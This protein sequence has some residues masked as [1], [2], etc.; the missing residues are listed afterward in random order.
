[1]I[2]FP[3]CFLYKFFNPGLLNHILHVNFLKDSKSSFSRKI[4]FVSSTKTLTTPDNF[5]KILCLRVH[6]FIYSLRYHFA[7]GTSIDTISLSLLQ[8]FTKKWKFRTSTQFKIKIFPLSR[9]NFF[10][11]SKN[12][13]SRH[14]G[15]KKI[16][17]VICFD[18]IVSAFKVWP[19]LSSTLY[20]VS[21]FSP[22]I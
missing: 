17:S 9:F 20:W 16:N 11:L 6:F 18:E 19:I 14:F 3:F 13:Y 21:F 22:P 10:H 15:W 4:W 1:M 12:Y 2:I 5:S 8:L 7:E